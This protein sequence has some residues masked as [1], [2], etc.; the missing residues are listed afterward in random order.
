MFYV[1]VA[2]NLGVLGRHNDPRFFH[3]SW[4]NFW[5][6][7]GR[8]G[9]ACGWGVGF[10]LDSIQCRLTIMLISYYAIEYEIKHL[11]RT[12]KYKKWTTNRNLLQFTAS[13]TK[14]HPSAR[15]SHN[16]LWMRRYVT[17][18]DKSINQI[19]HTCSQLFFTYVHLM[20]VNPT[21]LMHSSPEISPFLVAF[22][23]VLINET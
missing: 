12:P 13:D 19:S 22:L 6:C 17:F 8:P 16:Q 14:G 10:F 15:M 4:P 1:F 23:E 18:I 20:K 9:T 21:L 5:R 3:K 7:V 11:W 2:E